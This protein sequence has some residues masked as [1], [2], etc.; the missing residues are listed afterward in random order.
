MYLQL[1]TPSLKSSSFSNYLQSI[2]VW[3]ISSE[4]FAALIFD[5]HPGKKP[6]PY[7]I[8]QLFPLL[9]PIYAVLIFLAQCLLASSASTYRYGNFLCLS[10]PV[11]YVFSELCRGGLEDFWCCPY[12][13][14][15][16]F[17]EASE[18]PSATCNVSATIV[19]TQ[20]HD[21]VGHPSGL[22]SICMLHV[23]TISCG[24]CSSKSY[25]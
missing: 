9:A 20:Q 11:P 8:V 2:T 16:D 24:S 7:F 17:L 3:Y 19:H 10:T 25:R 18:G 14:I 21:K 1:H 6:Y 4:H 13:H 15:C 12:S 5:D 23:G 22:G